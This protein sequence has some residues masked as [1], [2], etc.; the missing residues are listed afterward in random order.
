[1]AINIE[2]KKASIRAKV[3]HLLCIIKC[4]FGFYQDTLPWLDEKRLQV[5]SV[6]CS[7][8]YYSRG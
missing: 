4:Q 5:G 7:G 1:M 8:E 2:C 3:V 6:I